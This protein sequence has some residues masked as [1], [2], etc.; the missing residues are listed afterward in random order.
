M[1]RQETQNGMVVLPEFN[2]LP[3]KINGILTGV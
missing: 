1:G 2:L 3:E